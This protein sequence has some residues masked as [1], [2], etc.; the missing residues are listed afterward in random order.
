MHGRYKKLYDLSNRCAYLQTH[1][2]EKSESLL[3]DI[4]REVESLIN[5]GV[6]FSFRCKGSIY[7]CPVKYE[8]FL[9]PLFKMETHRILPEV[10]A[11][12]THA[13]D[14][15]VPPGTEVFSVSDGIITAL[16]KDS[17]QGGNDPAFSGMDNYVYV[18]MQMKK[19]FF[20][21]GIWKKKPNWNIIKL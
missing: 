20:V 11:D 16:K 5:S 14:F 4:D 1:D 7:K 15:D 13:V 12:D 8:R 17:D 10:R 6:D 3:G 2:L 9:R 21:T 19:G 18:S